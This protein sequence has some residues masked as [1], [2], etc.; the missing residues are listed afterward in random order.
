MFGFF[1]QCD[2]WSRSESKSG[3]WPH[4]RCAEAGDD[5]AL[6]P[7]VAVVVSLTTT[8][9]QGRQYD[10]RW[11]QL[12][13][14]SILWYQLDLYCGT[15]C[16][17]VV[18]CQMKA[19]LTYTVS[20][21]IANCASHKGTN[22]QRLC[23]HQSPKQSHV[24]EHKLSFTLEPDLMYHHA[25]TH[26]GNSCPVQPVWIQYEVR[27]QLSYKRGRIDPSLVH[28]VDSGVHVR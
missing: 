26:L 19:S 7:C 25:F 20:V 27:A 22:R 8:A 24:R 6:L 11:Y 17:W 21:I 23:A 28:D 3:A 13:Y 2:R 1:P 4:Q 9:T 15:P 5:E 18:C 16:E 12:D 10:T 14:R